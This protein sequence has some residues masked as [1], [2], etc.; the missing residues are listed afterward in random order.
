MEEL[1]EKEISTQIDEVSESEG[2]LEETDYSAD[3]EDE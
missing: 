2:M 1:E 3:T